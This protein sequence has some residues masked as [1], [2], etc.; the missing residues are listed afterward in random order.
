VYPWPS[1]THSLDQ[2]GLETQRFA[3]LC[4]QSDGIKGVRHHHPAFVCLFVLLAYT[5][6]YHMCTSVHET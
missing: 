2:A 6:T 4:L 1:G 5:S 3:C